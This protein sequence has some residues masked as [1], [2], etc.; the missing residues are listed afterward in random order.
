MG[1]VKPSLAGPKRPQDRVLLQDVKQNFRDNLAPFADARRKRND[2]VQEDRLKNE[3]GGGTAVGANEAAHESSP[4]SGATKLRDGD[5]YLGDAIA[6]LVGGGGDVAD[7]G[8]DAACAFH[9]FA[10]CLARFGHLGRAGLHRI[11]RGADQRLDLFGRV[12]RA[13]SQRPHF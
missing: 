3:G 11:D 4:D 12:G 8:A 2:L 6:L 7:E 10:H 9:D 13:A 5:V 1:D